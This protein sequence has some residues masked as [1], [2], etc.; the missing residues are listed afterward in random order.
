MKRNSFV[1]IVL[2]FSFLT[3]FL[4]FNGCGKKEE[5][6]IKIGAILPLT[7]KYADLG[8]D[9]RAGLILGAE[10]VNSSKG[11]QFSILIEDAQSEAKLAIN[12]YSKL[13]T[14]SNVNI[15][16][17]APSAL[18]L[19]IKPSV[20]NDKNLLLSIAS[21]PDI[22]SDNSGYVLRPC[23]RSIDECVVISDYIK[24]ET[25]I[26]NKKSWVLYYNSEFGNSFNREI[27]KYLGEFYLGGSTFEDKVQDYKSIVMPIL[28]QKPSNIIVIGFTP[29]M[30]I[31]IKT[32]REYGF[33][34]NIVTNIGFT[35]E[36]ILNSAGTSAKG[37]YYTD[38]KF[39]FESEFAQKMK[40]KAM[41]KFNTN[42]KVWAFIS[43][44]SVRILE[45]IINENHSSNALE[46]VK[47]I[48]NIKTIEIDGIEFTCTN[49][50][51]IIPPLVIKK[52]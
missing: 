50:G 39:P 3:S 17:T 8:S 15:F 28:S 9:I 37:V 38:Y 16:L 36:S 43:Y 42:F 45:K 2:L 19:A 23:N 14:T 21:H 47:Y 34:G 49:E 18:S 6:V 26:N 1:V 32:L 5:D 41:K 12:A 31:L 44:Y 22:T 13:K 40:E 4:V 29:N 27:Y 48:K 33:E 20:I 11:K 25:H 7:G 10:E 24:N 52:Y 30:G 51:D 35:S 46:M